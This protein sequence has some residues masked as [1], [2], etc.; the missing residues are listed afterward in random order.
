MDKEVKVIG[1]EYLHL[2]NSGATFKIIDEG[3]GPTIS[4]SVGAFNGFDS[5]IKIKTNKQ[6]LKVLSDLFLKA[7]NEEYTPDFCCICRTQKFDDV[8][9][10]FVL[11]D[12][13]GEK[14]AVDGLKKA[15]DKE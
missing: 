9:A 15:F 14:G 3:W 2:S 12:T 10:K 8:N 4:I 11:C 5:E 6:S 13:A 7:S 1:S